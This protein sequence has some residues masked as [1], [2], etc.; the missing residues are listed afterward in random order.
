MSFN[1]NEEL[2]KKYNELLDLVIHKS[3]NE[4][5]K[6]FKNCYS[7][8]DLELLISKFSKEIE[9]N[10]KYFN[11][12]LK[13]NERI[14]GNKINLKII[15]SISLKPILAKD[16]GY[17]WECIQL[18]YAIYR[19]GDDSK[20]NNVQKVVESI[21]MYHLSKGNPE[22][23]I[24]T[25]K[26]ANIDNMIMDI[27]DTLRDNLVS[28]SKKNDQVNPI[29]NMIKT[30]QM[31]SQRYGEKLKSGEISMND[32]FQS[33]GRMMGE[34][35]KKT[36][37]DEEL[38]NVNMSE[39]DNPKQ[40][41][42]ELGIDGDMPEAV[43]AIG[44]MMSGKDGE[45]NPMNMVNKMMGGG[46]S[47]GINPMDMLSSMMG[48]SN[49]EAKELTPEQIKEMEEFYANFDTKDMS[50]QIEVINEN[51]DENITDDKTKELGKV[52]QEVVNSIST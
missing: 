29:E 4:K 3:N 10:N 26:P 52:A 6:V 40:M 35:D 21:E 41:M 16:D 36:S 23:K 37:Q 22:N 46:N 18:L 25:N 27:A 44:E 17:M 24:V 5:I 50:E 49:K 28:D 2:R 42:S 39:M 11:L 47:G 31:I 30:S 12:F 48:G 7:D 43:N 9:K 1:K 15:P 34:I 51:V 38:K 20:K 45:I 14:F 32:M 33:L 13:R 19:T 8:N